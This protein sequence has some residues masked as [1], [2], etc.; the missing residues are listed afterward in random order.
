MLD[1]TQSRLQK[2]RSEGKPHLVYGPLYSLHRYKTETIKWRD[3]YHE[4]RGDPTKLIIHFDNLAEKTWKQLGIIGADIG[5]NAE[6]G[7][8]SE[9][10]SSAKVDACLLYAKFG[11]WGSIELLTSTSPWLHH[12]L[13]SEREILPQHRGIPC[14]TTSTRRYSTLRLSAASI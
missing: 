7:K 3:Q 4:K 6:S 1:S 2:R 5:S 11:T 8:E 9:Q 13:D 14:P 12:I 10:L